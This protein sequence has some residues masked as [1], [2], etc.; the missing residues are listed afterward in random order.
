MGS[1]GPLR[2]KCGTEHNTRL[3][4]DSMP[5]NPA[6]AMIARGREGVYGAFKAVK[7]M[8]RAADGH[9]KC[10]VVLISTNFARTHD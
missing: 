3:A 6:A 9:F 8:A 2:A 1:S 10:L 5:K 7:C 4:F